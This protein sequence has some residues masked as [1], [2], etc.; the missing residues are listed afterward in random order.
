MPGEP[1]YPPPRQSDLPLADGAWAL[2]ALNR[3]ARPQKYQF[4]WKKQVAA[5]PLTKRDARF[6]TT[7]YSVRD[8][9]SK[10]NRG[11]TREVL[12]GDLASSPEELSAFWDAETVYLKLSEFLG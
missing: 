1:S 11:T 3:T 10:K 2:S 8:L 5:D 12:N 4:D 7:T 6:A 9:W